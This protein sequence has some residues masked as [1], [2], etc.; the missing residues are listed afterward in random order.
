MKKAARLVK[1]LSFLALTIGC[2]KVKEIPLSLMNMSLLV[3]NCQGAASFI[4]VL[5]DGLVD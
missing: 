1:S 5:R 4:P 2:A 3:W